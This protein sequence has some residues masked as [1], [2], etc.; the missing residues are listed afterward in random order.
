MKIDSDARV[1]MALLVATTALG[2]CAVGTTSLTVPD[3][4]PSKTLPPLTRPLRFDVCRSPDQEPE[5]PERPEQQEAQRKA[6]GDNYRRELAK[7]GVPVELTPVAGSP[8]DFTVT[9]SD[10]IGNMGSFFLSF[11]TFSVVPGY[12]A[13]RTTLGVELASH[14]PTPA[15]RPEHLRYQARTNYFIWLPLIVV[16]EFWFTVG[17]AWQ[18]RKLDDNGFKQMVGRLGDD[19]RV[20]LV[21]DRAG[22]PPFGVVCRPPPPRP[23]ATSYVRPRNR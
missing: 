15:G 10:G 2:A 1:R 19:L 5:R 23:P 17:D 4:L 22:P 8:V 20:R 16:P 9:L 18:S 7:A 12:A 21:G 11:L 13:E 3:R 14:D 6:A